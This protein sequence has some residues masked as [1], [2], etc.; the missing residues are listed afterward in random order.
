MKN[1]VMVSQKIKHRITND[2]ATLLLGLYTKE[3]KIG[4]YLLKQIFVI[5]SQYYLQ[6]SKTNKFLP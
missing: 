3:L 1:C 5:S 6:Q 4:A 2:P